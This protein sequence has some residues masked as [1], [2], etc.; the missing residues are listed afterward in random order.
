[1]RDGS[2]AAALIVHHRQILRV[3]HYAIGLANGVALSG[4][5][6]HPDDEG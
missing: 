3:N 1:M 5:R 6:H 2:S 4:P